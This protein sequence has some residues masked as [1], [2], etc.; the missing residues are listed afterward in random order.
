MTPAIQSLTEITLEDFLQLPETKPA[1]DYIKG[2]IYQKP[3]PQGEHSRLQARLISLIN[4][5]G[6]PQN[7]A[8]AFPELRCTF[9]GSAIVPDISVFEWHRIPQKQNGRV[10]NRFT[11]APDWTIEIWSPGQSVNRVM[12]KI[13]LCLNQ[14]TNLVWLVDPEDESV[15]IFKPNQ[16]PEFK[17]GDNLLPGLTV[18]TDWQLT[19]RDLFGWLYL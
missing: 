17:N 15:I 10:E 3:M 6:E 8:S 2:V 7:L 16:T 1:S 12:R 9:D 4:Q 11:I 13:I 19:A 5:L 14:G 18:L